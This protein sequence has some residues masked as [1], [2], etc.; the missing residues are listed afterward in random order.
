MIDEHPADK[1][2]RKNCDAFNISDGMITV[3]RLELGNLVH[4]RDIVRTYQENAR[5]T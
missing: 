5:G 1:W 3:D 2:A 4:E